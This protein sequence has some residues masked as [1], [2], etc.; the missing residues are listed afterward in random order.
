MR[1]RVFSFI[2]ALHALTGCLESRPPDHGAAQLPTTQA[3]PTEQQAHGGAPA[4]ALDCRR[5]QTAARELLAAAQTCVHDAD[6]V[7]ASI[8][9]P[10]LE[11]FFCPTPLRRTI[12]LAQLR[13]EAAALSA[14]YRACSDAC[15]VASCVS[16]SGARAIC[17]QS[18]KRCEGA[19]L[20]SPRL[21]AGNAIDDA[22]EEEDAASPHD[23]GRAASQ[24]P[25]D[26][27][28][29]CS[30]QSDCVIKNV[31]NCCGYYP[32][33]ANV[34]AVFEPPQCQGI[35]S[36]CGF[37]EVTSCECRANTCVSL[38]NGQEI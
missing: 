35:D 14:S 25:A 6:C 1:G 21:D 36:V 29:A 4:A 18:T 27:H 3:P 31:R 2:L 8:D 38:Q 37:P 22:G 30:Q 33:C 12:D 19:P 26:G 5:P 15:A 28:F 23:A 32:R 16:A 7:I 10:C 24:T 20:E 34:N 13:S 17:N 11:A 9:A